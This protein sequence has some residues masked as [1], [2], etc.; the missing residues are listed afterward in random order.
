[1]DNLIADIYMSDVLEPYGDKI[2]WVRHI[3]EFDDDVY[4]QLVLQFTNEDFISIVIDG[5]IYRMLIRSIGLNDYVT[6]EYDISKDGT[7]SLIK[8]LGETLNWLSVIVDDIYESE[9][10]IW[11][12]KQEYVS[13]VEQL[14]YQ[15]LYEYD[16]GKLD[17]V[18]VL[19]QLFAKVETIDGFMYAPEKLD[20][21]LFTETEIDRLLPNSKHMFDKFEY[22]VTKFGEVIIKDGGVYND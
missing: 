16:G 3:D 13:D 9:K 2:K 12:K 19:S 6:H 20:Q 21:Y 7:K 15:Y 10:Y 5:E 22:E 17:G 14:Q 4:Q 11:R 1:M 18:V 8:D